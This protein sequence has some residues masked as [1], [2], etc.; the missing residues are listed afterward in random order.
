MERA[1]D[2]AALVTTPLLPEHYL[3]RLDP[4]GSTLALRGRISAVLPETRDSATVVI[5]PGRGWAGHV[6][7]QFVRVA[8]D[9]DG[10]RHW[11]AYSLT[12]SPDRADGA[13]AITVTV[14]PG[15]TVSE[16]LV[17]RARVGD[18]VHLEQAAGDFVLPRPAPAKT[19]FVTAGSGITPV[20]GI[21]RD[22]L[23]ELSDVVVVHSART[24]SDVVFGGEL[25]MLD[26][27][28]RIRLVERHTSTQ[29][30]VDA[31][32]LESLVPDLD[33]RETW[34]CGPAGLLDSLEALFTERGLE[35]RLHVERFQPAVRA[36]GTGGTITF[37]RTGTTTVS[38]GSRSLLDAGEEAGVLMPSGCRM[39][40]CFGCVVPLREGSVRDLRDGTLTSALPGDGVL[41]QTCVTAAA[42]ACDLDL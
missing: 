25:R 34:A 26:G 5:R 41:V 6:P 16:H 30:R 4:L 7:G 38:D 35:A 21:L 18:L 15:G 3:D 42:G 31:D 32:E 10:V 9:V 36:T 27:L 14:V 12:W 2:L 23:D 29:G 13:I 40:I 28:R 19:L 20:M 37:T 8:V 11:R 17:R 39:G 33:E 24:P 22:R 1:R